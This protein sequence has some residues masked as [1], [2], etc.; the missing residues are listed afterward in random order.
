MLFHWLAVLVLLAHLAY[1]AFV[2]LGGLLV[3]RW[4]RVAWVHLP[5]VA[6]GV[7]VEFAGVVCPLTPLENMLRT[8]AGE[9]GYASGFIA[10]HLTAAIY[11]AGLTRGMEIALGSFALAVNVTLYAWILRRRR[12]HA[13]G[14]GDIGA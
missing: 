10:H 6:W 2:V 7:Y 12:R 11:P 9:P 14:G 1:L 5:A 8:H 3:L 13:P 4:P